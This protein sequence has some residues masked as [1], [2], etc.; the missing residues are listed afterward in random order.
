MKH[1]VPVLD[2]DRFETDTA[3]LVAEA[4][5]AYREYG[6]CGFTNHGIPDRVIE[7]A[8]GV[9]RRFFDLPEE[10]KNAYRSSPGGQRGYTPFGVEQARDQ[11][12]PDLKEFWHVGREL[13]ANNPWPDILEPNLWPS[14]VPDFRAKA[15]ALYAE[16]DAL[17]QR[18]LQ[19]IALSLGLQQD[20]FSQRVACGNSILRAIHYPPIRDKDTNAVRAARHEDINLITLLIGSSEEGLQ[21][22]ARDGSWVPV[23]SIPGTIV[24]NIGDMMK[25][26]TNHVLPSTPHRVINPP[27]ARS[28]RSRY[29]I[30][31]FMHPNP[32]F[33]IETLPG[34]IS[35][36]NPD[37]YPEGVT[38]NDFLMQR[39]REIKLF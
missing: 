1:Q 37:R 15:S 11:S 19:L 5:A 9:F 17:G 35:D 20:W 33:M 8:Y 7:D 16:L 6:F 4:G 18:V 13:T 23:T 31:F 30:P 12:I 32:D 10:R 25:R 22:L 39:L 29:S 28:D 24:V 21:I 36:A 27:G 38:A 2:L 34:C 14:E 26:L 3:A